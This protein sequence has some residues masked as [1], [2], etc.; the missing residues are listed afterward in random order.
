MISCLEE[1]GSLNVFC[2]FSAAFSA[3]LIASFAFSHAPPP[4]VIV[5]FCCALFTTFFVPF[6][7]FSSALLSSS[8]AV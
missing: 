2:K 7:A 1:L 5:P 8:T 4:S 3:S 6:F